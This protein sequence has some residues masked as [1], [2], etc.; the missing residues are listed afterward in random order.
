MATVRLTNYVRESIIR[1][2]MNDLPK[3]D[4]ESKAK[5][6]VLDAA[7]ERLPAKVRAVW[8][9]EKLRPYIQMTYLRTDCGAIYATIPGC[10]RHATNPVDKI[11]A[12]AWAL[13]QQRCGELREQSKQRRATYERLTQAVNSVKTVA[14]FVKQY[15]EL[16]KYAP[17]SPD[18]PANLPARTDLIAHL[19]D[20]G[21]ASLTKK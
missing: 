11:G 17:S 2:I 9:D 12:E 14:E 13:F 15:P 16:A 8:D 21:L 5:Q 10:D 3:E 19:R 18:N 7:V 6:E 4:I 20:A 1:A